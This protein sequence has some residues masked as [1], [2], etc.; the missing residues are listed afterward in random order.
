MTYPVASPFAQ[1]LHKGCADPVQ[2]CVHPCTTSV[3]AVV[4]FKSQTRPDV[5]RMFMLSY[6]VL[7]Q[8]TR[9]AKL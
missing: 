9:A 8:A 3:Q 6:L 5:E 7:L 4:K 1:I 2:K